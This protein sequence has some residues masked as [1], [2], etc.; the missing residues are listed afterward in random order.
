MASAG[1]KVITVEKGMEFSD[2]CRLNIEVN[3]FSKLIIPYQD[4]AIRFLSS[5][6]GEFDF[7]FIDCA[8]ESY[9][10]LL[11]LSLSRLV[12]NGMI[13]VDDVFFQGETLSGNPESEKGRGVKV[14]LDY[15]KTLDEY[16]KVILPIGNGL[17]ML[18][19]K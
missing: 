14:M 9:K 16:E 8:K 6:S 13:L 1:A 10:E 12:P 17:L 19:K 4:D 2:I 15:V 18:R 5:G 3:G 7:I 11:E